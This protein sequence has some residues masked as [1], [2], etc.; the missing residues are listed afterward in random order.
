MIGPKVFI[1]IFS[2]FIW[3]KYVFRLYTDQYLSVTKIL[4]VLQD[5]RD[6][7]GII[8][9]SRSFS[10]SSTMTKQQTDGPR[11]FQLLI[12][13]LFPLNSR[14]SCNFQIPKNACSNNMGC[15]LEG[16]IFPL[17]INLSKC[18]PWIRSFWDKTIEIFTFS[19]YLLQWALFEKW[20][21]VV[22]CLITCVLQGL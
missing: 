4:P 13:S 8:S 12:I 3:L 11:T 19:S 16:H 7:L 14:T 2:P 1:S 10:L 21:A 22:L 17:S 9:S 6:A 5:C 18:I 20:S 15:Y